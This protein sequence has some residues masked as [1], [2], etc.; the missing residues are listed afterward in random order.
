M[1]ATEA[2]ANAP[3]TGTPQLNK[4]LSQLQGELPQIKKT[5]TAKIKYQDKAGGWNSHE[6]SYADLGDVVAD[7]GPLLAK[8][9]LAFHCAPTINPADRREMLL[10]WSLLHE[11]GEEKSGEWPLGPVSQKPQSLG[12]AITYGRRYCFTA[13]TNIVL[14]DDDDGQRAQQDH[15]GAQSAGDAWE[16]A[17][18]APARQAPPSGSS[19]YE[20]ALQQASA[21]KTDAEVTK[22]IRESQ[23]AVIAGR[24]TPKQ[25]NHVQN[26]ISDRLK[27]LRAAATPV[28]VE[29]LA[30]A[31]H[32]S[33]RTARGTA[34]GDG[35]R[36]PTPDADA[37]A[38]AQDGT[39]D[40]GQPLPPPRGSDETVER[41]R[42]LVGAVQ[43][44]FKRLG[45]TIDDDD[46]EE[47]VVTIARLA[48]V[49]YDPDKYA[50]TSDF[51]EDDLK[52]AA[53]E[54]SR[55]KNRE[56]LDALLKAGEVDE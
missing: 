47:R 42:R 25:A 39:G 54:L 24:C 4:A 27:K 36:T 23:A 53:R 43:G 16:N 37:P 3:G 41:H 35:S 20:T 32:D 15:G 7:V 26:R 11:S 52:V 22:L 8:H 55:R 17:T 10:L 51:E 50:S 45:Y 48:R 49:A 44:Q 6:Y 14:E 33:P 1:T 28:D 34:A 13:A 30:K 56:A 18:P 2:E 46:R 38:S 5:K 19:W 9:G 40:S 21:V 31:A 12:S 29:D